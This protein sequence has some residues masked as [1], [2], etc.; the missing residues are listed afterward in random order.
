MVIYSQRCFN[1]AQ[2]SVNWRWKWQ[3]CFDVA[4]RCLNQAWNRQ[5]WFDVVQRCKFQR[6]QT[7]RWFNVYL[8]MCD[9]AT[10]Y[11]PKTNV[12]TTLKCLLGTPRGNCCCNNNLWI[13]H[14][15][16]SRMSLLCFDH[17]TF[18]LANSQT[19][20]QFPSLDQI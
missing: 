13:L 16:C 10:S 3:R 11:Q 1:V 18:N 9:V 6:W 8:T 14:L 12:D 17:E 15:R 2:R 20:L 19:I 5:R 7:Q 4:W